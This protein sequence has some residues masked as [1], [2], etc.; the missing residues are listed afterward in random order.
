MENHIDNIPEK[1]PFYSKLKKFNYAISIAE[2]VIRTVLPLNSVCIK[3]TL[4][5]FK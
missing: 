1:Q 3:S 4:K 5:Q 2:P